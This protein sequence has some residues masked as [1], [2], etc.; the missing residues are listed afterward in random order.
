MGGKM[1]SNGILLY[2]KCILCYFAYLIGLDVIQICC[3]EANHT[4]QS[5]KLFVPF[6][7]LYVHCL[8]KCL[9]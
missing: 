7:L 2:A 4:E 5:Q 3:F 6:I 1:C 8:K 9:K